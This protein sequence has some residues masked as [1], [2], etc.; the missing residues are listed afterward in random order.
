M[1]KSTIKISV[2]NLVEFILRSGDLD[3]R[4]SGSSDKEAMQ[5]GSRLHRK[6]QGRMGASYQA[7][8][9]LSITT[10]FAEFN[11]KVGGR[12]DGIDTQGGEVIID[13]IKGTFADL[14][15]M[16]AAVDIHFA[17]AKCYAYIYAKEND[18]ANIS[19]QITYCN[20]ETEAIKRFKLNY[21]F[22]EL[23]QWFSKLINEYYK[24]ALFQHEWI[25]TRNQSMQALEF[26]FAYRAG[27]RDLVMG[28][29]ATIAR[30]KTLFIQA[31]TGIGKTMSTIFPSVRAVGEG[32]GDKLFYL[33]AKTIT[34]TVASEAFNILRGQGLKYKSI[35]LTAKDKLCVC[36]ETICNPDACGRAKGHFDRIND[37]IYE[38]VTTT[39][40]LGRDELLEHSAKWQVCPFELGLDVALWVDAII[41]DYNY[42]FDPRAKLKRFF[43]EN[44]KGEYIFL[45]DE[46]H[47]LVER[48][49]EMFSAVLYKEDILAVKKLT[50][51]YNSKL[52]RYLEKSNRQMLEYKRECDTYQVLP[53]IGGFE[54]NLLK[55]LAELE[56]FLEEQGDSAPEEV[57]DFYFQV[58]TF[59]MISELVDENYV[60]YGRHDDDG[61]FCLRLYCV[62]PAN[63]LQ[64]CLD[65]GNSAVFFSATLLPMQYYK[66]LF[67]TRQDDFAIMASSPFDPLNKQLL[68]ARD[69]SSKYTRRGR[70]EYQKMA[71][72]IHQITQAK[73][74]NYLIF[75]PSYRFMEAVYAIYIEQYPQDRELCLPQAKAMTE[76]TRE[77]FLNE[78]DENR[79]KTLI[80][81][82]IMG[83][84]FAEGIDLIGKRLI[85]V[86]IVGTGLPQVGYER[87]ILMNFYNQRGE[88]GFDYAYR[89]PGMNK[90]LQAAGRVI[91]TD[92]DTGII[93]LL[94]ERF[95]N[96]EYASLFPADWQNL[97]PC[98]RTTIKEQLADFW[99]RV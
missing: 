71:E 7:E 82:G 66:T 3:E 37:A 14:A 13:E 41:C 30:K 98:S 34:K 10:E 31:P 64:E 58:R 89:F 1:D 8:V 83:G 24:W 42:V 54:I 49:R 32:L 27:Q 9:P 5:L 40:E 18:L 77:E 76:Q 43:G 79:D 33:T 44:T 88:N 45:I 63:N 19:V 55:V 97:K 80:G 29:Y 36:D 86:I 26:P 85:G 4:R 25:I 11:L 51:L 22:A 69:V 94:D 93:A 39:C 60:I 91:R 90:V 20:M 73:P 17:Q 95:L 47:N 96:R 99:S 50:S 53:N 87:E 59:L 62:N 81:F 52:A 2:R 16:K 38:L 75:F 48:G 21:S 92:T 61:R 28:V 46:A 74:G 15:F 67:S 68:L 70:S 6:I 35:I 84:I 72:Y 12:A 23:E 65:K 57:L 78:F 56:V